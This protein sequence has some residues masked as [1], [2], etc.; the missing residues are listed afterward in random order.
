MHKI[1]LTLIKY[2]HLVRCGLS[3]W[4]SPW[5]RKLKMGR[6]RDWADST[7]GARELRPDTLGTHDTLAR[8]AAGAGAGRGSG[9]CLLGSRERKLGTCFITPLLVSGPCWPV[10]DCWLVHC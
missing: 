2:L 6:A 5:R 4:P 8:R 3:C 1:F 10:L 9:S 7:D